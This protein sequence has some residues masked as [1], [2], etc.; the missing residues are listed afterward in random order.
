MAQATVDGLSA[1][2]W[3]KRGY[4]LL[5]RGDP[6]SA[7]PVFARA[8]QA[9]PSH[10]NSLYFLGTIEERRHNIARAIEFYERSLRARPGHI[11]ASQRL[12]TLR[13]TPTQNPQPKIPR[14]R[15]G[16]DSRPMLAVEPSGDGLVGI[17][18]IVRPRVEWTSSRQQRQIVSLRIAS[19]D[20]N[21]RAGPTITAEMRGASI[22]GGLEVGDW[23][24]LPSR[25]R[26][27]RG[28]DRVMNLST[29]ELVAIRRPPRIVQGFKGIVIAFAV[30]WIVAVFVVAGAELWFGIDLLSRA[31]DWAGR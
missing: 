4:D 15:S 20:R 16:L 17:V 12:A 5:S 1:E 22:T 2:D 10:A 8:L 26:S 28:L 21:G 30:V 18:Q 24:Q 14:E 6:G 25:W 7:R 31:P 13:A 23:V 11:S 9:D 27:G 19:R 29:G 3:Y